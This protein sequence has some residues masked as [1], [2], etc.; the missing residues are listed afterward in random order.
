MSFQNKNRGC[1]RTMREKRD[2]NK[3]Q[4]MKVSVIFVNYCH[5]VFLIGGNTLPV[6]LYSMQKS[7]INSI[8]NLKYRIVSIS[9]LIVILFFFKKILLNRLQLDFLFHERIVRLS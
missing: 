2:G 3:E 5:F 4:K 8:I 6:P 9:F 7:L 1:S